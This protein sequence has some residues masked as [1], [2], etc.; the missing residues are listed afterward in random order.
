MNQSF[1]TASQLLNDIF[2]LSIQVLD[3]KERI[4]QFSHTYMLHTLQSALYPDNLNALIKNLSQ[5]KFY[6]ISDEFQIHYYLVYL[7]NKPVIIGPFCSLILARQDCIKHWNQLQ[8]PGLTVEELLTYRSQF[9]VISKH[10]AAHIVQSF[11][12]TVDSAV[13]N[14]VFHRIDNFSCLNSQLPAENDVLR[15]NYSELIQERYQLEQRFMYDMEHG[16]SHAAILNLR[17]MQRDVAF[18]KRIGTTLENERI[19]AAIVRTMARVAAMRAGLPAATIDLLSK[20]N[21]IATFNA[22][23][24]ED[25]YKEKEKMVNRFCCEISS[26]MEQ[27]Y[28]NLILTAIHY[29]EHQYAQ[30]I[31]VTQIA[32]E[33]NVSTNHLI[34]TFKKE[35]GQT[36]GS[37]IQQLRLQQAARLLSTTDLTV[38]NIS[39]MV[40]ISD[41]NY[42]IKIFRR[43]YSSTPNQYRKNNRL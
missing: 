31:T 11:L 2:H 34:S 30:N 4:R 15:K 1:M 41:T 23:S 10:D 3:S 14:P 25:I 16:N 24:V 40:G 42:F 35:T 17:N 28:S 8:T 7:Q 33:L 38:Q 43:E 36:P 5:N 26:H 29:I 32:D 19:G 21:T 37:Y 27:S 12:H 13:K 9:P 18:L 6:Y 39:T 20:E 22:K